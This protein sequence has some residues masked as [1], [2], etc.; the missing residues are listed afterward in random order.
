MAV[1]ATASIV[2]RSWGWAGLFLAL[3]VAYSAAVVVFTTFADTKRIF[4]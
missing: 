4:Q 1:R 2:S 3:A